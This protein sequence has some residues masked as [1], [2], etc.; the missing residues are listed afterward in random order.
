MSSSTL[1]RV[2]QYCSSKENQL[3][4][5]LECNISPTASWGRLCLADD[6][7][8]TE[9]AVCSMEKAYGRCLCK[10]GH[11]VDDSRRKCIKINVSLLGQCETSENCGQM[12]TRCHSNRCTCAI[13]FT[14]SNGFCV[15]A[16][17]KPGEACSIDIECG[18]Y[19]T[20]FLNENM[21]LSSGIFSN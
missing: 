8:D 13:G 12:N 17:L 10:E 7:C 20:C 18:K 6:H 21:F 11:R 3:S 5:N 19:Q 14:E 1:R 9:N 16:T 15:K 4:I 2:I